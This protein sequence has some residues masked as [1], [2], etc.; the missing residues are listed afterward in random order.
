MSIIKAIIVAIN[1]IVIVKY[2]QGLILL[3]LHLL[4]LQILFNFISFI[5]ST[6]FFNNFVT[7]LKSG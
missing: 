4:L 2:F 5:G 6:L 1:K 7:K 3:E